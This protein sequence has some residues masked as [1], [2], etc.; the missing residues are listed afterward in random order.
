MP[1]SQ[2]RSIRA[3]AVALSSPFPD[4]SGAEPTPPNPPQPSPRT[5][6]RIPVRP[7]SRYSIPF[8]EMVK[9]SRCYH[10]HHIMSVVQRARLRHQSD[11]QPLPVDGGALQWLIDRELGAEHVMAYRLVVDPDSALSH[12]H[13]GAEEVLYVLEGTGEA[14]VEGATHQV[15]A[16]HAMFIPEGAEHSY[17]NTGETPL[18]VVGAMAPPIRLG[19][20]HPAMPR[21]DLSGLQSAS[22]NEGALAPT[23]MDE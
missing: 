13:A 7:N 8:V 18:V 20:I 15:G 22:L 5:E 21:L 11:I 12:V 23:M 4:S 2:A 9:V 10:R 19:D 17:I 3:K 1:A 16:G 6:T 14:R